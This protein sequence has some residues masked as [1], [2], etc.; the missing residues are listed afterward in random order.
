M[1]DTQ[2]PT[3]TRDDDYAELERT[4]LDVYDLLRHGRMRHDGGAA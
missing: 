3:P 2:Q 1:S 4:S